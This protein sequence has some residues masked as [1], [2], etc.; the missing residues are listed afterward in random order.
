[1]NEQ[2]IKSISPH[3]CP[4][5]SKDIFIVSSVFQ[6]VIESVI[7]PDEVSEAKKKFL[8]RLPEI[9][10]KNAEEETMARKWVND[11]K[12]IFGLGDIEPLLKTMAMSQLT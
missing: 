9:K 6:P 8:E 2:N 1:M 12:T 4:H 7:T 3:T 5:C 10:F 11:E